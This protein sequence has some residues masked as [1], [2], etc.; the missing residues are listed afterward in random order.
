[1]ESRFY[2]VSARESLLVEEFKS[3]EG[4]E[5]ALAA[6]GEKL[7]GGWSVMLLYGIPARFDETSG[8]L[9]LLGRTHPIPGMK[10]SEDT[11][12]TLTLKGTKDGD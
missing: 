2:V 1:M 6:L 3:L 7:K 5:G 11:E 8:I 9:K 4:E 10:A 12:W